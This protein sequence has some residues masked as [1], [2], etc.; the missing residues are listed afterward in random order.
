MRESDDRDEERESWEIKGD[1]KEKTEER[2]IK[3]D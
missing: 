2:E 3:I 1:E